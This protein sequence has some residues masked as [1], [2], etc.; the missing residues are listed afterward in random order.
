MERPL[1][2][3]SF[4]ERPGVMPRSREGAVPLKDRRPSPLTA[5]GRAP[6]LVWGSGRGQPFLSRFRQRAAPRR[7][8][9]VS[10]ENGE[11]LGVARRVS[12]RLESEAPNRFVLRLEDLEH[13]GQL[14]DAHQVVAAPSSSRIVTSPTVRSAIRIGPATAHLKSV[15]TVFLADVACGRG[16]PAQPSRPYSRPSN[17]HKTIEPPCSVFAESRRR[18]P[19]CNPDV[20]RNV[21]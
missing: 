12:D 9:L 18:K 8:E 3:E 1:R 20:G 11:R 6:S 10:R 13:G 16:E 2:Q 15:E 17:A 5:F 19:Q 21:K 7:F 4:G 14:R